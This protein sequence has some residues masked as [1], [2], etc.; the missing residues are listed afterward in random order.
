[1]RCG[2]CGAVT[3]VLTRA[4]GLFSYR[5]VT[6]LR[7]DAFA[8][9]GCFANHGAMWSL[10]M[11]R[12]ADAAADAAD[13][14]GETTC[15]SRILAAVGATQTSHGDT[16]AASSSASSA[17]AA[18]VSL[19]RAVQS[20]SM[21]RTTPLWAVGGPLDAA[22]RRARD[23]LAVKAACTT[24]ANVE[25]KLGAVRL[26]ATTTQQQQQQAGD[27]GETS[28]E[29]GTADE[30]DD[31]DDDDGDASKKKKHR[32]GEVGDEDDDDKRGIG[33]GVGSVSRI[34]ATKTNA[35][36]VATLRELKAIISTT[37]RRAGVRKCD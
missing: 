24:R 30:D 2:A 37:D 10:V 21:S 32:R 11:P 33:M 17:A 13:A 27:A 18:H 4:C 19:L 23:A 31:D 28:T 8:P 6:A 29:V 5:T 35:A 26:T 34:E 15:G 22:V 1:M 9:D 16:R 14:E 36:A 3:C 20:A 12:H 25:A 7:D